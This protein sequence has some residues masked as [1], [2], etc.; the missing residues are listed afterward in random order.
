MG[1]DPLSL[2]YQLQELCDTREVIGDNQRYYLKIEDKATEETLKMHYD[3]NMALD[4]INIW[5]VK[6]ANR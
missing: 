6:L 4:S 5:E 1:G 2:L 3:R